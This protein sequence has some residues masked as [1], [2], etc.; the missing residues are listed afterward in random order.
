[1]SET[2]KGLKSDAE[3]TQSVLGVDYKLAKT[4]KVYG[5]YA[6]VDSTSAYD[7]AAAK[8]E[9]KQSTLGLGLEHKF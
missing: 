9:E 6:L 1:M 3:A 4:T 2:D 7:L 8:T 5:Y